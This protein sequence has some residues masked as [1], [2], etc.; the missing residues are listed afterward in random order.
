MICSLRRGGANS[1]L[2]I[3]EIG[4]GLRVNVP[5][6]WRSANLPML[7]PTLRDASLLMGSCW[8]FA[9]ED[10][11]FYRN[12]PLRFRLLFFLFTFCLIKSNKK[13]SPTLRTP[14][15]PPFADFSAD[16]L[17]ML[18]GEGFYQLLKTRCLRL[19]M[20]LSLAFARFHAVSKTLYS[21]SCILF[22]DT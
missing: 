5:P 12:L 1:S 3:A 9:S 16:C 11:I 10:F 13:S 6:P 21:M 22:S 7:V 17:I 18:R 14:N 8:L 19:S 4:V 15:K 2:R 20:L